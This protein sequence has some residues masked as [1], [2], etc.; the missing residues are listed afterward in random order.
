M[1]AYFALQGIAKSREVAFSESG[2]DQERE[3]PTESLR[4]RFGSPSRKTQVPKLAIR[5]PFRFLFPIF[6]LRL[7]DAVV[8][9]TVEVYPGPA[10]GARLNGVIQ[11]LCPSPESVCTKYPLWKYVIVDEY[12]SLW[13]FLRNV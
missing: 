12:L 13:E 6:E 5:Y 10:A 1:P 3:A 4:K 11:R 9:K 2:P 8:N 7:L